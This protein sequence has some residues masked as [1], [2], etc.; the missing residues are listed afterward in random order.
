VDDCFPLRRSVGLRTAMAKLPDAQREVIMMKRRLA[1][2]PAPR[3]RPK[4]SPAA[5]GTHFTSAA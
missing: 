2:P 5:G 1:E 4:R 3:H